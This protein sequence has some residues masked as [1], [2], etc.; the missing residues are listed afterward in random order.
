MSD[1][2]LID[3]VT[4]TDRILVS[5]MLDGE[6]QRQTRLKAALAAN[7]DTAPWVEERQLFANY[8]LLQF[9]DTFALY[10][11]CT[12]ESRRRSSTFPHVPRDLDND[13]EIRVR[14]D[15]DDTYRVA[16]YPFRTDPLEIWFRGR[17]LKPRVEG[18]LPDMATVMRQ[19]PVERQRAVLVA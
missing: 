19:T 14:P 5:G 15:G 7:N 13:V 1:K 18:V 12:H 2:V 4:E 9:F 8:K 3:T 6:R 17:Y 11:N 16:P 10:F